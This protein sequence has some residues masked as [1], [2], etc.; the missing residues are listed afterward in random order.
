MVD[1]RLHSIFNE[2]LSLSNDQFIENVRIPLS[3]RGGSSTMI[4]I[5][6]ALQT[7]RIT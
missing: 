1:L 2:F 7:L 6:L 4:L 5:F 3:N